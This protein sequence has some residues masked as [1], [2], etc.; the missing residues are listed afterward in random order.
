MAW[1]AVYGTIAE[2]RARVDKSS[3]ADDNDILEQLEA[4]SDLVNRECHRQ[5]NQTPPATVRTFDACSDIAVAVD[6]LVSL[7]A[8]GFDVDTTKDGTYETN[9]AN[10]DLLLLPTLASE[11]LEPFTRIEL[12]PKQTTLTRLPDF[13]KAIQ[14]T[15]TWG[16]SAV[17]KAIPEY[18][19]LLVR[20]WRDLQEGGVTQDIQQIDQ[21]VAMSPQMTH[22][23]RQVKKRFGR[24][25][26][27][28]M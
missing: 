4:V 24:A 22:I 27:G 7:D 14:I 11:D 19:Y 21:A 1:N 13:R 9:V 3:S 20:M 17:P 16:W 25:R 10:D 28:A 23:M 18:V 26:R 2:Y 5:F 12:A 15:G 6:D 8:S